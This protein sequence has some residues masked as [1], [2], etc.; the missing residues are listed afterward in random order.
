[1]TYAGRPLYAY[2]HEGPDEVFCHDVNL[3]G[4]YWWVLD[5]E[6]AAAALIAVWSCRYANRASMLAN[7]RCSD[8]YWPSNSSSGISGAWNIVNEYA[9]SPS[10]S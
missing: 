6:G 10:A 8:S 7:S 5:P 2:A 3:N 4:G 9:V 1:M